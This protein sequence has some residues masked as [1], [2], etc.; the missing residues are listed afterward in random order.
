MVECTGLENRRPFTGLV[1]SNLTLSASREFD[2]IA[3]R[4]GTPERFGD[5]ARRARARMA[6][7][8]LALSASREFDKIAGSDFGRAQRARRARAGTARVNLTLSAICASKIGPVLGSDFDCAEQGAWT[9]S[10]EFDQIAGSDLGR[11]SA[12][13]TARE[14]RGA[15][16]PLTRSASIEFDTPLG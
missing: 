8:H 15:R 4:F 16:V 14:A 6:R 9:N 12:L 3:E 2:Q 5:G 1:S 13:A 11:R 7:V 10:P